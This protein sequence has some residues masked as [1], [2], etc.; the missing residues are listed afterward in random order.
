MQGVSDLIPKL[1]FRLGAVRMATRR[2]HAETDGSGKLQDLEA[3]YPNADAAGSLKG[4]AEIC[5]M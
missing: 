3:G 5:N 2:E 1:L 4:K